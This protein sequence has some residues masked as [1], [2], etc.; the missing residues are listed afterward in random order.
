MNDGSTVNK[1]RPVQKAITLMQEEGE[2]GSVQWADLHAVFLAVMEE[3]NKGRKAHVCFTDSWAMENWTKRMPYKVQPYGNHSGNL[4]STL[5]N[6]LINVSART[7]IFLDFLI[8]NHVA[9]HCGKVLF[10]DILFPVK[11]PLCTRLSNC[12]L[13]IVT[14]LFPLSH[15]TTSF[16]FFSPSLFD[17]EISHHSPGHAGLES[18][19]SFSLILFCLCQPSCLRAIIKSC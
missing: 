17:N 7:D 15:K 19:S 4:W 11:W 13:E 9:D 14:C 12:M 16:F 5:R 1:R 10:G 3:M 18:E 6:Q 2:N 8:D